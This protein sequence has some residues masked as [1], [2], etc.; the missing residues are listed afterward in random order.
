VEVPVNVTA[1][2]ALPKVDG[3]TYKAVG[4]TQADPAGTEDGLVLFE[5]GSGTSRFVP[6]PDR[7]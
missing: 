4:S 7:G 3:W 5:V 2:V 6:V 1:K